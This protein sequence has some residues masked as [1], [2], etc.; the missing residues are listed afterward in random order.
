MNWFRDQVEDVNMEGL[1]VN[2]PVVDNFSGADDK[3][4]R[5]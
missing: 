3:S 1:L 2:M 5:V 4:P